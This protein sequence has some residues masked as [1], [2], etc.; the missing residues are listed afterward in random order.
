MANNSIA[1]MVRGPEFDLARAHSAAEQVRGARTANSLASLQLR[2]A[3]DLS[4]AE[5]AYRTAAQSGD[6]NALSN[7]AG[8]PEQQAQIF[9]ALQSMEPDQQQGA[10]DRAKTFGEAAR[11]VMSF[12][13]GSPERVEAWNKSI[14][15]LLA[16]EV[17]DQAQ[18]DSAIASGPNNMLLQQALIVE[19]LV[20]Q[21]QDSEGGADQLSD[22]DRRQLWQASL[23]AARGDNSY[24]PKTE[25]EIMAAAKLFYEEGLRILAGGAEAPP[26]AVVAPA[27]ADDSANP[28]NQG[29][30]PVAAPPPAPA[31]AAPPPVGPPVDVTA[32]PMRAIPPAPTPVAP[33]VGAPPPTPSDGAWSLETTHANAVRIADGTPA[34]IRAQLQD[35]E[36]GTPVIMPDGTLGKR[37]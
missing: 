11:Y 10:I 9:E 17:I 16:D 2:D 8:Y 4:N 21:Y 6:P 34:Q 7:L 5:R 35:L 32:D 22:A 1:L 29:G 3:T 31:V 37:R 18:A 19:D 23:S 24:P 20:K 26:P 36:P 15:E 33:A 25:E 30:R 28:D 13:E 14:G 12:P 27:P